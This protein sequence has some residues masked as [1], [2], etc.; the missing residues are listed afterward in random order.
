[1]DDNYHTYSLDRGHVEIVALYLRSRDPIPALSYLLPST[2]HPHIR[3]GGFGEVGQFSLNAWVRLRLGILSFQTQ[4]TTS[5]MRLGKASVQHQCSSADRDKMRASDREMVP[6]KS[7]RCGFRD[8]GGR[9]RLL[10]V[11]CDMIQCEVEC[12]YLL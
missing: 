7:G 9:V 2:S 5:N 4:P 11:E 3:I 6:E 8:G 12:S 1:M 10:S